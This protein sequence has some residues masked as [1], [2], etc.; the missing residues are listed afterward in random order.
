MREGLGAFHW[1]D[2]GEHYVGEWKVDK[3][4]GYGTKYE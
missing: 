2:T 3:R 1:N 4:D